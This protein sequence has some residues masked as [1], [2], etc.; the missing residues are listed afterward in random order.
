M[1]TRILLLASILS[2]CAFVSCKRS[3]SPLVRGEAFF[4]GFGCVNC[5]RIGSNGGTYG[6]DLTFV[7]FRKNS[8]WLD[9]WLKNPHAWR[10]NTVM[11]N[12]HLP[13]QVRASLVEYLSSLKGQHYGNNRPWNDPGLQKDPV[14]QG[15]V[16][17]E[18][19][20]CVACHSQ[21]GAGGYPNNNVA[22]GLIP[23]LTLVAD[24]YSKPELKDRIAKGVV[25]AAA[26]PSLPQPMIQMPAWKEVLDD[27]ELNALVEYLYSLR[28]KKAEGE[29]W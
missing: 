8:Q 14:K 28:P 22:G 29:E 26:D 1:K 20:G 27:G 24:G 6:P 23:P 25:P 2:A 13:D 4:K 5:H 16:I 10:N 9:T 21:R 17:F 3:E 18:K 19:A 15:E 12:F 11:P 7:G